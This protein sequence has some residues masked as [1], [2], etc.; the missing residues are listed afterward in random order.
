MAETKKE[1]RLAFWTSLPFILFNLKKRI[2]LYIF[3]ILPDGRR[4]DY[5]VNGPHF[6][7]QLLVLL[8]RERLRA[9][10]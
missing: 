5:F 7:D 8:K 9:V 10:R 4:R 6:V 3:E 1:G 2:G